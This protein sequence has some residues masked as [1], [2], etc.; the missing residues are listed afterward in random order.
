[1]GIE[2]QKLPADARAMKRAGRRYKP[3]GILISDDGESDIALTL[4]IE[5]L[6]AEICGNAA[7]EF[8]LGIYLTSPTLQQRLGSKPVDLVKQVGFTGIIFMLIGEYL[9]R[10]TEA[11][12]SENRKYH[13]F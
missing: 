11:R 12:E 3:N 10:T 13:N 5:M 2:K 1:M 4:E 7:L 6:G 9:I 8:R